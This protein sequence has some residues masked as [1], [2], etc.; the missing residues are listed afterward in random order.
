[1]IALARAGERVE[2][3]ASSPGGWSD[4][5]WTRGP[6]R[7]SSV[8]PRASRADFLAGAP[9]RWSLGPLTLPHELA[10][11]VVVEQLY[12][13]CTILRGEPYHKGRLTAAYMTE[14]FEEWF[15]EEYLQP[16]SRTGTTTR[17]SGPWR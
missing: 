8:A 17:R 3:R 4:G 2:Q 13:A 6:S 9:A 1:M 5:G 14:W 12:R 16:L 11:V 10:R 7:S 15:G